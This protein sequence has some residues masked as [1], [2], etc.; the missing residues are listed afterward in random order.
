MSGLEW[1]LQGLLLVL[2]CAAMPFAW[3][4]ERALGALRRDRPALEAGAAG[5]TDATRQAEAALI[6]LRA[7]AEGAGKTVAERIAQA[8]PLRD[9]LRFLAERAEQIADRLEALVREARPLLPDTSRTAVPGSAAPHA[10]GAE[11]PRSQAERDLL[12]A[13]RLAR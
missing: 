13:L 5:F 7:T 3:R 1:A 11:E 6:R 12:R 10:P 9:D 8:E 2:L 4:L